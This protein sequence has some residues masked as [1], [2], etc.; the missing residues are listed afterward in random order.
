MLLRVNSSAL[1][2]AGLVFIGP[3]CMTG[4]PFVAGAAFVACGGAICG[5]IWSIPLCSTQV[6]KEQT[7]PCELCRKPVGTGSVLVAPFRNPQK[8]IA[9]LSRTQFCLL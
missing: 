4:C 6:D 1:D 5:T 7:P 9:A 2:A 3:F 8:A